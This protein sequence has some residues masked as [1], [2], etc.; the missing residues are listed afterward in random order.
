MN[1]K[2]RL[3]NFVQDVVSGL[4][5]DFGYL[6]QKPV[7]ADRDKKRLLS[8]LASRGIA[9]ITSELPAVNKHLNKCLD[10]GQYTLLS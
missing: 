6:Y 2:G 7:E 1:T 9:L 5:Q 10:R 3:V 8:Q 4:F